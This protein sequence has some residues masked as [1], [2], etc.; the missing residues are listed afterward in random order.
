MNLEEINKNQVLGYL[1][2]ENWDKRHKPRIG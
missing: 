1:I 2:Q